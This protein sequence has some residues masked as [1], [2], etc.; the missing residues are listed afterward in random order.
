MTT[1]EKLSTADIFDSFS[2]AMRSTWEIYRDRLPA[3]PE[4]GICPHC[5]KNEYLLVETGYDRVSRIEHAD[6]WVAWT[7]GWDDI[8]ECGE[9][10]WLECQGCLAAFAVPTDIT[11]S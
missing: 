10:S 8:S 5:G 2:K 9:A 6:G 4:D 7:N 11:W 1:T 3:H